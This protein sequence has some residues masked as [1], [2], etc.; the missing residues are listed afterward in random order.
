MESIPELIRIL[1]NE[2]M[3]LEP[4]RYLQAERYARSKDSKGYPNSY[5]PK[6]VKTRVGEIKFAENFSK[7]LKKMEKKENDVYSYSDINNKSNI[8]VIMH[9]K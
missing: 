5:K 6:S 8:H 3:A 2:A 9:H 7:M 1:V 4:K